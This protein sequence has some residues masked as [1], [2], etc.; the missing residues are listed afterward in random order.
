[1]PIRTTCIGAYP[2][3]GYVPVKDWFILEE[4]MTSAGSDVTRQYTDVMDSAGDD[5]EALFVRGTREAVEDQVTAG[6]DI[7]TDGE[8]RRENYIHY[9]CRHLNG[10][11][12]E[13]LTRRVVRDGA[14]ETELPTISGK[15]EPKGYHFLPKDFGIAQSCTERPVKITVPGPVTITDTT[16]N[17]YYGSERD[18]AFDLADALN[19]EIRALAEAGC[20]YIQVDEP[21]FARKVE[22]AND[23]GFEALERCFAG[24]PSDVRRVVHMCCGYPNHLDDEVYHKADPGCY[25]RL[26]EGIEQS[27]VDQVSIEDA[28]RHNDLSLLESFQNTTVI[29]GLVA[30]AKSRVEPVEEVSSRIAAA[31]EHIDADRLIAAP[32]CGLGLLGRDLAK[33]K[34][35]VL[36]EAAAAA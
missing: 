2:K 1:M 17:A 32:D 18:L 31:L 25:P 24:V 9:H 30:I 29:L 12:F 3:P 28:H 8:I 16:A 23:Y 21:L 4:G 27:S 26:A 11:D 14:Y 35:A 15:I 36:C 10:F 20:K 33:Q 6:V 5:V 34:L 7:P 22:A 19:F 13:N